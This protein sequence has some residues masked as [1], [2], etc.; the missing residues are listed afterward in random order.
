MTTLVDA[1]FIAVIAGMAVIQ[2]EEQRLGDLLHSTPLTAGEYVW[3]KF[4]AVAAV[5]L[6]ALSAH[7]G[8]MILF[9]HAW[10]ASGASAQFLGGFR[11][12]N[13]LWPAL[14]FYVPTIVFIAGLAFAV[15]EWT[16]RPVLVYFL[17]VSL[18]L[19]CGFFLWE[20]SPSW[21]DPR[22]DKLLMFLDP[23]GFRWLTET[24]LK[25]D[26]GVQFY[27]TSRVPLDGLIVANRLTALALGLL[28]VAWSQWHLGTTLR[29]RYRRAER[30][31]G[32][33]PERAVT[34]TTDVESRPLSS[35]G[36][37][38]RPPGLLGG[39]WTVAMAEL[40]ELRSSPGLYL[41]IPLMLLFATTP[42]LVALGPFETPLL[43]TPGTFAVRSMSLLTSTTC[44][45]LLFYTVESLWRER[46]TR[47]AAI[48]MA[49]PMK[50]GSFLIGKAASN[51][52]VGMAV[53]LGEFLVGWGMLLY[54][55]RVGMDLVPF[56]LV[57]GLLLVP[58]LVL[59]TTYVMAVMSITRNRYATYALCLGT[60]MFTGY[61]NLGGR[62]NW[63]G[64]W[65]L[66]N[67]LHWSDIS[68]LEYDRR[69]IVM[70][71]LFVLGLAAFFTALTAR[72]YFRRDPDAIG[73]ARRLRP[74]PLLFSLLKLSPFALMP[75]VIGSLLWVAVD[76]GF[77][78]PSTMNKAKDYWRKNLATY[79]DWPLPD[80]TAVDVAVDLEPAKRRLKASGTY[81][82]TNKQEKPIRQVPLTIGSH[83][84][85]P[86][87]TLEGKS[88]MPQDRAGLFVFTLPE[89][90][91][92]GASTTIGYKFEGSY[93][94]GISENGGSAM[95]F[96]V[97]SGAVLTSFGPAFAP[98]LGYNRDVGVDKENSSESKEYA[99]DFYQGQTESFAGSRM[100]Y[101]TKV[102]ITGPADF[103]LNS[104]GA[105]TS[106]VVK[107]G[108]R[109]TVWESDQPVNFFNIVAGRWQVKKGEGTAIYY[110]KGHDYNLP[111]IAEA[112]DAARKYYSEWFR[113]YPWRELKLSEFPALASYA[114]GFPTDITFSESIG[115][116]TQSSPKAES[117]FMVTAHEAAHQWF[118]NM[119][120]PGKGPGGNILAEGTSHFATML[121]IDQV[122]GERG[123]IAFAKKIE[124]SYAK[125]RVADSE[126]PLVKVDGTKD[127]DTTV[128][129]DKG[130]FVFWML[131]NQMGR[132]R[133][134]RGVR[135]YFE[136]YQ[137]SPDHPVIQ[138]FLAVMREESAD[139]KAF[140]EFTRQWFYKVVVPEYRLTDVRK[141]KTGEKW[142]VTAT[143][144]NFGTGTMPIEVAATQG[145]RFP[146][147]SDEKAKKK[148]EV[149]YRDSRAVVTLGAG[150]TSTVS[151]S[152]DFEPDR[153]IVDPDAKVLQLLRKEAVFKF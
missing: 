145:E 12:M 80:I 92:S 96:I 25:V 98:V 73:I 106:D 141:Q 36:M 125:T 65:G 74:G 89:P 15:G 129:Y 102:T 5:A 114:Q 8:A 49:T 78:G 69:A 142:V 45:L 88:F 55:G 153:V 118:G 37:T 137:A 82:L 68:V 76:Q 84:E 93:P 66:F 119:V 3:G 53:V 77:Q 90:L 14:V 56:F 111:E 32:A 140:D 24:H 97:P 47:L 81:T 83:W 105:V 48:G 109:T 54:Q 95:E 110:H 29:G 42:N 57:W 75:V 9:N 67:A 6:L 13:Y 1:F 128:T 131:L 112:L 2:D 18:F 135:A 130:G 87:W 122:Q 62:M 127:G 19:G 27:N 132:D 64:N 151:I 11:L 101:T 117:A 86:S 38:T 28:A 108:R 16:R 149:P 120:A 10:H 40:A 126:R 139:P 94:S 46:Q 33:N 103:T 143:V 136:K 123:R 72:F 150:E 79:S 21:L 71:R 121:L 51:A 30:T 116:L 35:L 58:T 115:F 60:L 104:V 7:L 61:R 59:W 134:L 34:A 107:D 133:A 17:P 31:W 43:L 63:V 138:D 70:N 85:S 41:F 44:L 99:D 113:P 52:V 91:A 39:A 152:C 4:A 144:K 22:V 146:D 147:T 148:A 100:P 23:S 124:D 50:T 26:R 20:W